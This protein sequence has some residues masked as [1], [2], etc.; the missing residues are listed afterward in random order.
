M[1]TFRV[2]VYDSKLDRETRANVTAVD[3]DEAKTKVEMQGLTFLGVVEDAARAVPQSG[4]RD[5][6]RRWLSNL[7]S[8]ATYFS[9]ALTVYLALTVLWVLLLAWRA[10]SPGS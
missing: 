5:D 4:L 6:E 8:T 3:I 10:L 1:P 9:S 2:N 7:S